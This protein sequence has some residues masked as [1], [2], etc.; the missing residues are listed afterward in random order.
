MGESVRGP[1]VVDPVT[2]ASV[3]SDIEA[4]AAGI[5]VEKRWQITDTE[6]AEWAITKLA[7]AKHA[8]AEAAAQANVWV[9]RIRE[10]E[11]EVTA[12][13][14]ATAR[15]FEALLQEYA[16]RVREE[17]GGKTKT[18]KLASGS[19]ATRVTNEKVELVDRDGALRW[20]EA[21]RPDLLKVSV[22]ASAVVAAATLEEAPLSVVLTC[23]CIVD[24]GSIIRD[25]DFWRGQA[26]LADVERGRAVVCPDCKEEALIGDWK[27]IT[28]AAVI[29]GVIMPWLDVRSMHVSA[30]VHV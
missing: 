4:V 17:S 18:V 8:I 29:D 10:W 23:G 14:V 9:N 12:R 25:F 21:N 20:C 13:D 19:I 16:L 26:S 7:D 3:E 5:E 28:T 27:D 2:A 24:V 30:T 15:F 11:R 22:D 6:S 1:W